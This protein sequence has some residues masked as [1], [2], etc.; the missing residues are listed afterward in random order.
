MYVISFSLSISLFDGQTTSEHR[1]CNDEDR[2]EVQ[3]HH[4][5]PKDDGGK[6]TG[7]PDRGVTPRYITKKSRRMNRVHKPAMIRSWHAGWAHA[8]ARD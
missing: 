2:S 7:G 5:N 1:T 4:E 8:C 6:G 3:A